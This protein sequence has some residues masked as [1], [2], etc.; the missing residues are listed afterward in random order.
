MRTVLTLAAASLA[1]LGG[2]A[3]PA[4]AAAGG[5]PIVHLAWTDPEGILPFT[6]QHVA[7]ELERMLDEVGIGLSWSAVPAAAVTGPADFRVVLLA[8]DRRQ[9]GRPLLGVTDPGPPPTIWLL[10]GSTRSAL[11]LD[12]AAGG[13]A[14]DAAALSRALGRVILHELVHAA[15]PKHPHAGGGLMSHRVSRAV[16]LGQGIRLDPPA[17]EALLKG[18][19]GRDVSASPRQLRSSW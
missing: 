17:R 5:P 7:V 1:A 6:P 10:L 14:A 11:G 18:L 12:P 19:A 3:V 16:L 4:D 2:T 15:A 13:T 8:A 9:D